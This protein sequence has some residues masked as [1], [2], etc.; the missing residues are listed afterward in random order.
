M[1]VQATDHTVYLGGS[2]E[3]AGHDGRTDEGDGTRE[4]T[5]IHNLSR[6]LIID[7][8]REWKASSTEIT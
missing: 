5:E 2:H 1:P 7:M 6:T 4:E 8:S 3:D